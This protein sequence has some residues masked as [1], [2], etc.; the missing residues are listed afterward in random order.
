[1]AEKILLLLEDDGLRARMGEAG[2]QR[3]IEHFDRERLAQQ[4]LG[5]YRGFTA[6]PGVETND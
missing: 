2:R 3:A 4:L 6:A 5:L 1:L